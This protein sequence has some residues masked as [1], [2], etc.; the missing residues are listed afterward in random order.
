MHEQKKKLYIMIGL[1]M[2]TEGGI[3]DLNHFIELAHNGLTVYSKTNVFLVTET[4]IS[5]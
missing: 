1:T 2:A 4:Q 3:P 5:F